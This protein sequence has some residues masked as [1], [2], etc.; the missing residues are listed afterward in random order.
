M[1]LKN[2]DS[3]FILFKFIKYVLVMCVCNIVLQKNM[4]FPLV[5]EKRIEN[6]YCCDFSLHL[7]QKTQQIRKCVNTL[8]T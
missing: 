5:R 6:L 7:K 2:V 4:V 8:N 1:H 3:H